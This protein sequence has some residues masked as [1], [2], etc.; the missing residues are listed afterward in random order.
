MIVCNNCGEKVEKISETEY[1]CP[2]CDCTYTV[3][4]GK[5]VRP[6]PTNRIAQIEEDVKV[7]KEIQGKIVET[8][9]PKKE[10]DKT[11][12]FFWGRENGE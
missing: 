2:K 12:A 9:K 11:E 8:L 10:G 4:K 6:Q 5:K 7:I 1:Y 3:E